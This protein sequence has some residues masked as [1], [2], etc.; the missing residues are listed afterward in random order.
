MG[1]GLPPNG[2]EHPVTV[3]RVNG[4]RCRVASR[5][6]APP[7]TVASTACPATQAAY[8]PQVEPSPRVALSPIA[9][10]NI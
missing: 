3:V 9:A 5:S 4:G 6:S 1:A 7:A 10:L 8:G 2:M